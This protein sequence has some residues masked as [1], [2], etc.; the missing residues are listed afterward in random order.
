MIATLKPSAPL[1]ISFTVLSELSKRIEKAKYIDDL[2]DIRL[3]LKNHLDNFPDLTTK[4]IKCTDL[5]IT[6]LNDNTSH[7]RN[8]RTNYQRV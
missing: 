6:R 5:K 7:K 8:N 4:L 3:E 1:T 2:L